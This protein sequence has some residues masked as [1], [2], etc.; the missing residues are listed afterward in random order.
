[1]EKMDGQRISKIILKFNAA[2]EGD[3]GESQK[4]WKEQFL[5]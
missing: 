5:L 3:P 2:S 4:R 1:M